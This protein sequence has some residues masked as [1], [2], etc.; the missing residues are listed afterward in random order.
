MLVFEGVE[1][2]EKNVKEFFE[3]ETLFR[4]E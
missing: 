3:L 4:P 2:T 1:K